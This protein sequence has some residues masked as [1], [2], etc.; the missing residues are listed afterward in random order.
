MSEVMNNLEDLGFI[1]G[2][3]LETIVSTY[4]LDG[5]PTAAPMGVMTMDMRYVIVK[6]YCSTLTF[7]NLYFQRDAVLNLAHALIS[8]VIFRVTVNSVVGVESCS[9]RYY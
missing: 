8:D 9:F 3:I 4:C 6:P 1:K 5:Q 7:K 2:V